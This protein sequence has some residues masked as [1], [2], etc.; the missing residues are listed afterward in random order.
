[1]EKFWMQLVSYLD[2]E[3]HLLLSFQLMDKHILLLLSNQIV[4]LCNNVPAFRST[5]ASADVQNKAASA[6]RF[7]WVS[8]QALRCMW[9]YLANKFW[10]HK[11]ISGTFVRFL[12][13]H[14]LD[15]S[16]IGLKSLLDSLQREVKSISSNQKGKVTM[17]IFN[18]LDSK[19]ER[20][21]RLIPS[22]KIK[23]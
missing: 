20:I 13:C 23:D 5:A 7:T 3:Y 9:G 6:A 14:M 1:M 21:L 12:T 15:Q 2:K 11:A 8:L 22:P 10:H 19:V 16:A 17:D 4:Q 18:K